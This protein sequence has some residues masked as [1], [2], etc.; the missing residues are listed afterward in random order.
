MISFKKHWI[1][2]GD[3]NAKIGKHGKY[4]QGQQFLEICTINNLIVTNTLF[5]HQPRRLYTWLSPDHCTKNQIDYIIVSQRW[6][7]SVKNMHYPG[8]D[9]NSDHQLLVINF[10]LYKEEFATVKL[11]QVRPNSYS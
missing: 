3:A 4:E 6:R 7:S 9:C 1:T 10:K 11:Y 5:Q 2:V 8:V